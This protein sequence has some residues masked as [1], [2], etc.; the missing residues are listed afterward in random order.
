MLVEQPFELALRQAKRR[1]DL[2]NPDRALD[3][4]FH[5]F[6]GLI[7]RL[8]YRPLVTN[9]RIPLR[10]PCLSRHRTDHLL[11]DFGRKR[12]AETLFDIV[13]HHVEAG[14]TTG[15]GHP[16][17]VNHKQLLA[18]VNRWIPLTERVTTMPVYRRRVTLEQS[19]TRKNIR[20]HLGG[21]DDAL[22]PRSLAQ[23]S[24]QVVVL[25]PLG[26]PPATNYDR[27]EHLNIVAQ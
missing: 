16:V 3:I 7:E 26:V 23:P 4:R 5:H 14:G 6:D 18:N 22:L 17:A 24:F 11:R 13:Q 21:T 2:R 10:L 9:G 27:V 19:G 20:P 8:W 1:S 12:T 15:A 25:I